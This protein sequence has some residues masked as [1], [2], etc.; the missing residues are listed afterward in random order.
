MFPLLT[1]SPAFHALGNVFYLQ[2]DN[3]NS[4]IPQCDDLVGVWTF[5]VL[6][7]VQP[8]ISCYIMTRIE[9]SITLPNQS[10]PTWLAPC[11]SSGCWSTW[12]HG[13]ESSARGSRPIPTMVKIHIF[14]SLSF[15]YVC[16]VMAKM[17]NLHNLP[18]NGRIEALSELNQSGIK[19]TLQ[20]DKMN[21]R[22][23]GW[24]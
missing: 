6:C 7:I 10:L 14:K 18:H 5:L 16:L 1:A 19:K 17:G 22:F 15:Q 3:S 12:C 23:V 24:G 11:C 13:A 9:M 4:P 20:S 8:E 21:H 2:M